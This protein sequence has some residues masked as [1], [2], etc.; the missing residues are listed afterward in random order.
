MVQ[1]AIEENGENGRK[2]DACNKK[3]LTKHKTQ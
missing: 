3:N 1:K 2:H